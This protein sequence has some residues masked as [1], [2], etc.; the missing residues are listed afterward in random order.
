MKNKIIQELKRIE[1]QE[2]IRIL[3]AVESGSRAW[4]FPS[5]DSD[6]DVRFIY[7]RP[8]SWYLQLQKTRDT[9]EYPISELLD[10]SGWDL[11]KSLLLLQKSNPSLIEWL[12]SPIVYYKDSLF[13][14]ELLELMKASIQSKGLIYHY[15]HM[16]KGNYRD[17]LQGETVKIKKYFYVL[18]PLLACRWIEAHQTAPPVLFQELLQQE[19]LSAELVQQIERLLIKKRAGN[20]L[21]LEPQIKEINQFIVE[22]LN[23]FSESVNFLTGSNYLTNTQMNQFF[24][25]WYGTYSS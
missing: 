7:T 17:Y 23:Y 1:K 25:Q 3:Y 10:I 8:K 20:E 11:D 12:A 2:N 13:H 6:Y 21:G 9:L 19:G 16:A 24:L 14:T 4:G 5:T 15:L 18:R 22:Q